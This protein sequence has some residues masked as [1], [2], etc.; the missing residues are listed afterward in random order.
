MKS[1]LALG[2]VALLLS[3]NTEVSSHKLSQ[4]TAF[5]DDIVKGLAELDK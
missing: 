1:Y 4:K 3:L 2:A 5:V